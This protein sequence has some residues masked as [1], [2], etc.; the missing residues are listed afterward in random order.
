MQTVRT[1]LKIG[2]SSQY[3]NFDHTS[4]CRFNGVTLAAGD[5]GLFKACT[6]ATDN[7]TAIPATFTPHLTD[8]GDSNLKR[9]WYLY[10]YF[11]CAG[12]LQIDVTGDEAVALGTYTT[13]ITNAYQQAKK[14]T[15][16]RI[17]AWTSASFKFSN[18]SGSDFSVDTVQV[19]VKSS[20]RGRRDTENKIF[21][22]IVSP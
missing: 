22:D 11:Q 3:S 5:A 19:V 20:N 10:L 18:V 8:F 17:K 9:A 12:R 2:A 6:G 21:G 13:A 4:M 15:L 1:N 14:I 7:G 16:S